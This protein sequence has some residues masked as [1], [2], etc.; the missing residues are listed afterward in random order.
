MEEEKKLY[1]GNLD[2]GLTE[3]ELRKAIEDKGLNPTEVKI[4]K[5]KFSEKSKGFGFAEFSTEEEANKAI[6]ALNEE[7]INGRALRVNK[8]RKMTPRNDRDFS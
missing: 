5:D 4:I 7:K 8:A 3:E 1:L 6:E 2:F